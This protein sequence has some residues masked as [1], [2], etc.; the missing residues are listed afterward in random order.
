MYA[1]WIWQW[2]TLIS[3]VFAYYRYYYIK[4]IKPRTVFHA[5]PHWSQR[6]NKGQREQVPMANVQVLLAGAE[7]DLTVQA[8]AVARAGTV[9]VE[10]P[11]AVIVPPDAED[12][13]DCRQSR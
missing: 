1:N 12:S 13:P 3:R 8:P 4:K 2:E 7:N 9:R 6:K 11:L 5:R 10:P